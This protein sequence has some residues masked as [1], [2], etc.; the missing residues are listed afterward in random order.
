M[1]I[2]IEKK[3]PNVQKIF[4]EGV[5]TFRIL[6]VCGLYSST[7]SVRVKLEPRLYNEL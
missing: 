7:I 3:F 6:I 1:H 4:L 5:N 2:H